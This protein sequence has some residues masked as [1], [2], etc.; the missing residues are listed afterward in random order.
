MENNINTIEGS[1]SIEHQ[2]EPEHSDDDLEESS[3]NT[4]LLLLH[5]APPDYSDTGS[6]V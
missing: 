3:E 4:P 2:I 1:S 6:E 5:D